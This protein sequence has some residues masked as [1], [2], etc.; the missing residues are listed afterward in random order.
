MQ[1][2]KVPI[3]ITCILAFIFVYPR[4]LLSQW[5]PDNPWLNYLYQYGFGLIV[6][7]LGLWI[8]LSQG[9][10]KRLRGRDSRWLKIMIGGFLVYASVHA[11]WILLAVS[12]PF[13]GLN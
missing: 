4:L 11:V 3:V 13:K 9:S 6:F 7:V 2:F 12:M 10:L 1:R 5:E 8:V